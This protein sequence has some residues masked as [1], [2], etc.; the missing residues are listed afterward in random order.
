MKN[1]VLHIYVGNLQMQ[2]SY[3]P[4]DAITAVNDKP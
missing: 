3:W 1:G 2:D 4:N